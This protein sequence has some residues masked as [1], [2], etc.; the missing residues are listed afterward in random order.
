MSIPELVE[1]KLQLKEMLDKGYIRP[2]VSPWGAPVL[3][4]RKKDGTLRLCIDYRQLNKVTIK[5]RYP[6][7]RIDD[8]FD[9]LKGAAVFSKI[10]LRSGYHQVCIKEEDIYKTTFKTRILQEVIRN[11]SQIAYSITSLKRKGKTFEWTEEFEASFEQLK[12][13][14]THAPVLQIVDLDKKFVSNLNARQARW[15]ATINEF[16]FKI[17]YIKGK[18]NRVA[19]ALRTQV[20]VHHLAA[21]SSYGTNLQ[22]RILQ[23]G[24]H[25]VRYMEIV[26]R[27]QQGTSTGAGAQGMDYCL[28]TDGLVK[29]RDRIYVPNNSELKKVILREFHAK[30]YS[31]NPGYQKTLTAVKKL[32]YWLNLKR[33]VAEFMARCFNC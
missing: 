30:P 7:P 1:L 6:L 8:L 4:V 32:Y 23:E 10:D 24:Q 5:N 14:S 27:L 25:D 33:D 15:L 22:N 11:F 9:Q 17:K 21:M 2:S 26:H 20:Q 28:K 31:G 29:F 16:D 3:F 18:E 19:D 13:L 12:Q